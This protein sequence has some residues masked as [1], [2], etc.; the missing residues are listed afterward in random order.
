MKIKPVKI[1]L[2]DGFTDKDSKNH[3][4]VEIGKLIKANDYFTI[5]MLLGELSPTL[6]NCFLLSRSVTKF[7]TMEMPISD[8][9][10]LELYTEDFH[11]LVNALNQF[12]EQNGTPQMID[13]RTLKFAF[14]LKRDGIVYDL[15]EFGKLPIGRDV[16][17]AERKGLVG[18]RGMAYL[19]GKEVV[20]LKQ[21]GGDSVLEGE[22][23]FETISELYL[24]DA[25]GL[26]EHSKVWNKFN[27]ILRM[28]EKVQP[29]N[30]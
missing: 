29:E 1:T 20:R 18:N 11:D 14:G 22:L 4:D 7:G 23:N 8:N 17:E 24:I 9:K 30:N 10:L 12:N 27:R 15:A 6:L 26:M 19:A 16:I 21:S 2:F 13:E 5:E 28:S 25:I 3:K